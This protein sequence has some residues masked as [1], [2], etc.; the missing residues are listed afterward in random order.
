MNKSERKIL[1]TGGAGYIGSHTVISLVEEGYN[2]HILDNLSNSDPEV[3][4]RIEQITKVKVPFFEIDIR[5]KESLLNLFKK[6]KYDAVIHFAGLKAVGISVSQPLEYYENNVVGTIRLLEVMK[7]VDCKILVFSSSATV[8]LPKSTPLNETDPLGAS[9]PYGQTKYIIELMMKDIY[10]ASKGTKFSILRYFNP[11]GC[12]PSSLIGED[13]EEP[14]NLLPYI[15][16]VSVGRKEKLY[17]FGDDWPTRDGTGVRD[18]IHVSDLA[19]GHVKALEKLLSLSDLDKTLD[20]YNLGCGNGVSVLEMV[21]N[22]EDASGKQIPYEITHR[23][24]GDLASVI[25]DP[26]KAESELGWKAE[27]SIFDACKS[28]YDWQ[29]KNPYGYSKK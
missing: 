4:N 17:V 14:N 19:S 2:V 23:R 29:F 9:N 24:P 18:Y 28:A 20:I 16:L 27:K 10:N 25:A 15:Q 26:S 11:V 5:D 1:C 21:K 22:F 6:E 12:H 13:P 3:V 8:Y 7:E